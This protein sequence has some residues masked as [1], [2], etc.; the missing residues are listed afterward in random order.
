M[1]KRIITY[2][3]ESDDTRD[4]FVEL[5]LGLGFEEQPDQSTYAQERRNPLELDELAL[6][7]TRWSND[8]DLCA[9][10]SVQ[11]YYLRR[12]TQGQCWMFRRD[13]IYRA[14]HGNLR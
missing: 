10:D 4:S 3:F 11:I 13:M 9:D 5:L 14:N 2:T 1:Y 6:L 8:E 7:I 12:D